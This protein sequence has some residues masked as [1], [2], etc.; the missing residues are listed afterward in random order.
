MSMF[1]HVLP[2]L[3]CLWHVAFDFQCPV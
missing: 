1:V 3:V 2:L